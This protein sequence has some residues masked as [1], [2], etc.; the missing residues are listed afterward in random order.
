MCAYCDHNIVIVG[1]LFVCR[2]MQ[3]SFSAKYVKHRRYMY[4]LEQ[5]WSYTMLTTMSSNR[6]GALWSVAIT[7]NIFNTST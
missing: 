7:T 4:K 3:G 1:V 2:I 5:S 6:E